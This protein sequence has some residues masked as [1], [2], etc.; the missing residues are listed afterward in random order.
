MRSLAE[1]LDG[2]DQKR[3]GGEVMAFGPRGREV[4]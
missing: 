4:M 2:F 1:M 3:H